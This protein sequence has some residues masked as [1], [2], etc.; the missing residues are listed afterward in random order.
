MGSDDWDGATN[1]A[2]WE[3]DP[4]WV[5]DQQEVELV[6]DILVHTSEKAYLLQFDEKNVWLP[7]S[8]ATLNMSMHKNTVRIPKWL[9]IEKELEDYCTDESAVQ[10]KTETEEL[11]NKVVRKNIYK[12]EEDIPF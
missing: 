5:E 3:D 10:E 8:K 9:M 6:F 4:D 2:I 1:I 7:K 12:L 11:F